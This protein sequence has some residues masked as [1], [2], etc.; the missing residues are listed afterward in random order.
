MPEVMK[1]GITG[2]NGRL[3]R[4][5]LEDLTAAGCFVQASHRSREQAAGNYLDLEQVP[6]FEL[7]DSVFGGC[8]ALI[9]CAA[10]IKTTDPFDYVKALTTNVTSTVQ[11][12]S[13]ANTQNIH[14]I[15]IS[16]AAV[17]MNPHRRGIRESDECGFNDFSKY[18]GFTKFLAESALYP[19]IRGG[20]DCTLLRPS[21]VYGGRPTKHGLIPRLFTEAHE[22]GFV[23]LR[24]PVTDAIGLVHVND[25]ATAVR[26]VVL[27]GI[28]GEFNVHSGSLTSILEIVETIAL[29]TG[30]TIR[31]PTE[32][33]SD[34]KSLVTYDLKIDQLIE[35]GWRPEISLLQGLASFM[36]EGP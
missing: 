30:A 16:G 6:S 10:Q 20:L 18:Y 2:A 35:T 13:W 19:L 36:S 24:P 21:S 34:A 8:S 17:Y 3:G 31:R 7:L 11:L 12:A 5:I 25:V 26:Q 9:H 22:N 32:E 29:L 4:A 27:N 14:F 15:F 23:T 28:H 33:E 1:V